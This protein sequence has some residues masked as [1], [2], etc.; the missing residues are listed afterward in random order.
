MAGAHFKQRAGHE[1]KTGQL[2]LFRTYIS[3]IIML[4]QS[5]SVIQPDWTS[6]LHS[7]SP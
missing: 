3:C 2:A 6:C 4:L 7:P 1:V 5:I